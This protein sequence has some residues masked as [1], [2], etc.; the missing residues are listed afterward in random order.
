MQGKPL[1]EKV[2]ADQL[3]FPRRGAGVPLDDVNGRVAVWLAFGG[4]Y[5]KHNAHVLMFAIR[6]HKSLNF[7]IFSQRYFYDLLCL[8][9]YVC[10]ILN[11]VK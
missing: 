5:R 2:A 8:L 9:L 6:Y 10:Y 4:Q 3:P 1:G 7:D 11:L